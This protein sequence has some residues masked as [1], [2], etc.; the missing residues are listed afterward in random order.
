M[1]FLSI[2]S[3]SESRC[4]ILEFQ[5]LFLHPCVVGRPSCYFGSAPP[6]GGQILLQEKRVVFYVSAQTCLLSPWL[7]GAC[8]EACPFF[9]G[10]SFHMLSAQP[11]NALLHLRDFVAFMDIKDAGSKVPIFSSTV[12]DSLQVHNF[13]NLFPLACLLHLGFP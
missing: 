5:V 10:K 12:N 2:F 9:R 3:C 11:V 1:Y 4:Y 13:T 8:R 6:L 7:N